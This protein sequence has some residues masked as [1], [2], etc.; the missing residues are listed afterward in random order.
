[1]PW[2]TR[3]RSVQPGRRTAICVIDDILDCLSARRSPCVQD[4]E[5]A[6]PNRETILG[7]NRE[8]FTDAPTLALRYRRG[9]T[10]CGAGA[11]SDPPPDG[12]PT[13]V[14]GTVEKLD[15]HNLTVKSRDGQSLSITLAPDVDIITLVKKSLAD[16]K[17]GDFVASTG[18]KDKDGK[19]HAIEARIFPKATPDGGRQFAWDLMPDSVMTNATV[20]TVTK[21]AQGAVLHVTFTGGESE[22]SIG[23]DVPILANAPGDMSLLKPGAAVFVIALKKPD[24]TVTAARLYAEKDGIKPPM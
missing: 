8:D 4:G 11:R 21:A 12:T 3:D 10:G 20:G 5:T 22:Y 19:I 2:P 15:D 18:V 14:R 16:I 23:P 17:P 7:L 9:R 1:M 13:R 6:R 24:G